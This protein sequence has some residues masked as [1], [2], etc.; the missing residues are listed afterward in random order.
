MWKT[1]LVL[2]TKIASSLQ[3][4]KTDMRYYKGNLKEGYLSKTTDFDELDSSVQFIYD[5]ESSWD[6][7]QDR[8]LFV[9]KDD[10]SVEYQ[11][12]THRVPGASHKEEQGKIL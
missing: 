11:V 10:S 1:S 2:V 8:S 6:R 7:T 3:N 4:G 9:K 12:H 5:P